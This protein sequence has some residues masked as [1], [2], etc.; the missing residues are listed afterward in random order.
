MNALAKTTDAKGVSYA[1]V[2]MD[3]MGAGGMLA[4]KSLGDVVAFASVMSRADLALPKH[5]RGNDGACM[6]VTMQA[7]RWEMDPFAVAN[8]TYIVNDRLAYEAQLVAAVVHTRAP[9]EGR[10]DYVYLGEGPSRQCKV[11]CKMRGDETREYTSPRFDQITTKNSPLWKSDPDQQLGYF[12]IRSWARRHTP[13]VILGVYTPEEVQEFRDVSPQGTGMRARLEA[14]TAVGGFDPEHIETE[15]AEVQEAEFTDPP[16]DDGL[17]ARD[18][19]PEGMSIS[20]PS[21]EVEKVDTPFPGDLPPG[22]KTGAQLLAEQQAERLSDDQGPGEAEQAPPAGQGDFDP[23]EWAA[24][25]NRGIDQLQTVAEVAEAWTKAKQDGLVG[26]LKAAAP[27]AA[28]S[29]ADAVNVRVA[30]LTGGFDG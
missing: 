19:T 2:N 23:L 11:T 25:F 4:P 26:R 16:T 21:S 29:L 15:L 20:S 14:R 17:P 22:V 18:D 30:E 28:K 7:M 13:E 3:Q 27:G 1:T 12:A 9:I 10:P 5:L 24:S 8:K 6:A